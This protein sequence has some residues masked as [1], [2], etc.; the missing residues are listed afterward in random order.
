MLWL[1]D[2]HDVYL[3]TYNYVEVSSVKCRKLISDRLRPRCG[4]NVFPGNHLTCIE[5]R[6]IS[7][8]WGGLFPFV[9]SSSSIKNVLVFVEAIPTSNML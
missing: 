1:C 6:D 3:L 5:N 9:F 2:A 7:A 4:G 8:I